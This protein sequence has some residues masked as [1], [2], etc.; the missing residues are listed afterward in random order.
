MCAMQCK[1]SRTVNIFR[2]TVKRVGEI[3]GESYGL[4]ID[5]L[6]RGPVRLSCEEPKV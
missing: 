1:L 4:A 3:R 5:L 2:L 6:P